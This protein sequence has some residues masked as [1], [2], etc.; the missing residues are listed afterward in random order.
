MFY[1]FVYRAM[2]F[3]SAFSQ[4]QHVFDQAIVAGDRNLSYNRFPK[5]KQQHPIEL[6]N[7][8]FTSSPRSRISP[9]QPS[10]YTALHRTY[11]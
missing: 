9:L 7:S 6:G 2:S 5:R 4:G 11:M 3:Y 10:Y 8:N 1:R